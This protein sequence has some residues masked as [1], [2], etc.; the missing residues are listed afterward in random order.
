MFPP[1]T[2]DKAAI[3]ANCRS[4]YGVVPRP[5]WEELHFWGPNIGTGSNIFLSA[6]K[7]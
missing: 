3:F 5:D 2:P 6:S 7:N 4:T 1:S